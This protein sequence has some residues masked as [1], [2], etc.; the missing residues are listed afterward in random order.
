MKK[1]IKILFSVFCASAVLAACAK[2]AV[3]EKE[4]T[5]DQQ[6]ITAYVNANPTKLAYEEVVEGGGAGM[7]STW[8]NGDHFLAIQ[9]GVKVVDFQLIS[10]AGT[11]QG[12]FQTLT[13]GVTSTT[14]WVGVVG[15]GAEAHSSEIHCTYM[16]QNGTIKSLSGFNYVK[17][18]ATG[19]E[20]YFNF[21]EGEGLSYVIRVKLPEGV[22]CVEYTP[23]V[24]KKV[25]STEVTTQYLNGKISTPGANG[26]DW[27]ND[28][29]PK[30]TSTITLAETSV[31]GDLVYIAFGTANYS[32]TF[33]KW[34]SNNSA[35][36]NGNLRS[37]I[38]IT[39]LNN[40]SDNADK[41][42]GWVLGAHREG[43]DLLEKGGLVTTHDMSEE[44]LIPRAKPS[45][46]IMI[47]TT[48][49]SCK[50]HDALTQQTSSMKTGWAPFNLGA[51]KVSEHGLYIAYGEYWDNN[52]YSWTA[53]QQRHKTDDK[54]FRDDI[55]T[56]PF[57]FGS[58]QNNFYSIAGSRFDAA[59]VLWGSAWRMPYAVEI[60]GMGQGTQTFTTID[61]VTCTTLTTDGNSVTFPDTGAWRRE[62][63]KED[64]KKMHVDDGYA[65]VRSAD[66]LQ[67]TYSSDNQ[68]YRQ[69][70]SYYMGTTAAIEQK[71][72]RGFVRTNGFRGY[73]V[74][75]VL[76]SSVIE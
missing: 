52:E 71:D 27:A 50:L 31:K 11:T 1:T 24:W 6:I 9:D 18:T 59:R 72:P 74:R 76:A 39:L 15:N 65:Y 64:G 14:Q 22:K 7:T 73:P 3:Q 38:V 43:G 49:I 35:K 41:S 26:D 55:M 75:A 32:T 34:P 17:V 63:D 29:G 66:K 5:E 62:G 47:S 60:Y 68:I 58:S 4:G 67:R 12:V 8:Q 57:R 70:Y 13:S 53:Y 19:E 51:S 44:I 40:T 56:P 28:Y 2:E 20:P 48:G 61:G 69:C 21:A 16:G 54:D 46:A 36:Q 25:T 33:Q 37:G 10:G 23:S 30:N 45:E 42:T